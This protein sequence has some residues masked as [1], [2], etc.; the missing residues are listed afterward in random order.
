MNRSERLNAIMD[1][2]A[3][4]GQVQI[5]DIIDQLKISP[6]TAR[7]DLDSLA[8]Q[9][10]LTRIRGGAAKGTVAYD[11]AERYNRDDHA[12]EKQLIAQAANSLIPEGAVIGLCGGTTS[13]AIAQVLST[14]ADL[15]TPSVRPALTVV[16]NA[17]N[18]AAQLAV[19][20]NIKIM[21]T[22]GV[23][24]SRSYELIGPFADLTL[25]KVALDLAFI[26]VNGI[27]P[28][29]GPTVND[30]GE[31]SVNSLMARRASEAYVVA[32]SSKIGKR[33]FATMSGFDFRA[34]IT[35]SGI[36]A[37]AKAA[38]EANGTRVII[39]E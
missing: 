6:A 37:A 11:L 39:A 9:R 28:V 17:I 35:D 21:V 13:T 26:G 19:R 2:L 14:R 30:E 36:T 32:D 15:N 16:T 29:V 33:A 23:V 4:S 18:I 34:L 31:A 10:L 20:P 1:L 7:R 5:D 25:Q 8:A 24:N 27:D 12:V 22:G 38:F 3:Q